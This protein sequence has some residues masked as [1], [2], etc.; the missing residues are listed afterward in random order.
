[1]NV[2]SVSAVGFYGIRQTLGNKL[3]GKAAEVAENAGKNIANI[4]E[5]L[6]QLKLEID[7]LNVAKKAKTEDPKALAEIEKNLKIAMDKKAQL[8]NNLDAERKVFY[9]A[10]GQAY[11]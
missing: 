1:M 2:Q 4:T 5:Q 3:R 8:E 9:G 6:K 11:N 7:M 10:T